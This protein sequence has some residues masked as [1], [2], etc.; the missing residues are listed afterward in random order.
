MWNPKNK[1]KGKKKKEAYR[2]REQ[3]GGCQRGGG[4]GMSKMGKRGS[5]GTNLQF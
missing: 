2:Y 4:L 5:K 3:I 1:T